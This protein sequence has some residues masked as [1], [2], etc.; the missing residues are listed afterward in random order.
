MAANAMN[1]AISTNPDSPATANLQWFNGINDVAGLHQKESFY[2]RPGF[3]SR[4]TFNHSVR[5]DSKRC[6]KRMC[7]EGS[8]LT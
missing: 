5:K 1:D 6:G 7:A 2:Y 4:T 8:S 3:L